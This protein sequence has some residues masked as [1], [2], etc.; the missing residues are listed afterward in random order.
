M[1]RRSH[2]A[3]VMA[4]FLLSS[5]GCF[6]C[7][8]NFGGPRVAWPWGLRGSGR[9]A[10]EERPVSGIIGVDLATFG[11]LT[12][13]VGEQEGLSIE[14]E[15]NLIPYC[16]PTTHRLSKKVNMNRQRIADMKGQ[17]NRQQYQH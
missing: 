2:L 10:E 17:G 14:A 12:I 9:M 7:G 15:D 3:L 16:E 5:L 6:C 11:D 4:V 8:I 1:K 13:E